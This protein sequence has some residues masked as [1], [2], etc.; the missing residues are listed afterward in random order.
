V[1]ARARGCGCAALPSR[2]QVIGEAVTTVGSMNAAGSPPASARPGVAQSLLNRS[3]VRHAGLGLPAIGAAPE[4][5]G[6]GIRRP[7]P[8]T[9]VQKVCSNTLG[10][11]AAVGRGKSK[12]S[13]QQGAREEVAARSK[14]IAA[15]E[16]AL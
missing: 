1:I 10:G 9:G 4:N 6:R 13:L 3:A 2:R 12:N 11:P 15:V 5:S 8:D 7:R 14:L 16:T